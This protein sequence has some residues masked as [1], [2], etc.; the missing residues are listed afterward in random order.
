MAGEHRREGEKQ[1]KGLGQLR[2]SMQRASRTR[3]RTRAAAV[4]AAALE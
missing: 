2:D 3:P 1:S 4:D